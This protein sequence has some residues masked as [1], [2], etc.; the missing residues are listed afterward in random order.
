MFVFGIKSTLT[1]GFLESSSLDD[2]IRNDKLKVSEYS[3][4]VRGCSLYSNFSLNMRRANI[5]I[6]R[7]K[8]LILN[9]NKQ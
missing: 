4:N 1:V 9:V 7:S 5:Y 8:L 3:T 2:L 6:K